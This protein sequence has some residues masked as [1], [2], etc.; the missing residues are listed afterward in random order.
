MKVQ[1]APTASQQR[2][3]QR[4]ERIQFLVQHQHPDPSPSASAS[5]RRIQ[6]PIAWCSR[7]LGRHPPL[8]KRTQ[9]LVGWSS[10][11]F[12][13]CRSITQY[14]QFS[15]SIQ[16]FVQHKIMPNKG[17][18]TLVHRKIAVL[19]FRAVGKTSLTNAFVSGTFSDK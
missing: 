1:S 7:A 13:S 19:G 15:I 10:L 11:P 8:R 18:P 12:I 14:C 3:Q 16:Q 17:E 5:P 2:H 6:R 9:G 4:S